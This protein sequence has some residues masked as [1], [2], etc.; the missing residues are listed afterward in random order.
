LS[1]YNYLIYLPLV[2]IC[3]CG[4]AL[5]PDLPPGKTDEIIPRLAREDDRNDLPGGS[6]T[7][8]G[9]TP[10]PAAAAPFG[11]VGDS[12]R[13]APYHRCHRRA[14]GAARRVPAICQSAGRMVHTT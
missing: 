9:L 7:L 10:G 13:S 8:A 11:A 4:R 6:F 2:V 14:V 5:I 1:G 3:I 12:R